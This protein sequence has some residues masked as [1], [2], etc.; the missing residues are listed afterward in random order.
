VGLAFVFVVVSRRDGVDAPDHGAIA[1]Q[2]Q[3][4]YAAGPASLRRGKGVIGRLT[5]LLQQEI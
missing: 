4:D 1:I 5:A 3:T 2:S